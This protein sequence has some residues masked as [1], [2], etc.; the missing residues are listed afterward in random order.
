MVAR[1]GLDERE[2]LKAVIKIGDLGDLS[3]KN[4]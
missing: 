3:S 4:L 2:N 1:A